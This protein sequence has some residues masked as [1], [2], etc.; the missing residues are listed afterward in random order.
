M[1]KLKELEAIHKNLCDIK[2]Q[3]KELDSEKPFLRD[4]GAY[5][6][7]LDWQNSKKRLEESISDLGVYI[8]KLRGDFL[9]SREEM[10][11]VDFGSEMDFIGD[12]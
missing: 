5:E 11:K 3:F 7:S 4:E 9:P 8:S 1:K 10:D 6:E 2:D 12:D